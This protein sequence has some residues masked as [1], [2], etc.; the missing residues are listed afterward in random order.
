MPD[1]VGYRFKI[2]RE[3]L[4]MTQ[5]QLANNINLSSAAIG[6]IEKN[7]CFLKAENL[8]KLIDLYQ[9]NINWLLTGNGK[10]LEEEQNT[11]ELRYMPLNF[12]SFAFGKRLNKIRIN[13]DMITREISMLLEI[14]EDRFSD[15]CVGKAKPTLEEITKICENFDVTADWLLFGKE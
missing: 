1:S 9:L 11:L 6:L 12:D 8:N 4:S 13:A 10:M 14:K 5:S 15:L 3:S 2:F 7:K